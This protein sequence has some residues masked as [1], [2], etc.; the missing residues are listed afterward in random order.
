[1]L[2]TKQIEVFRHDPNN[3]GKP[4]TKKYLLNWINEHTGMT[5]SR[6][7]LINALNM[8]I[9]KNEIREGEH[10]LGFKEKEYKINFD[11]RMQ[12]KFKQPSKSDNKQARILINK[13]KT[14][15]FD[16]LGEKLYDINALI[17]LKEDFNFIKDEHYFKL[18]INT[19][20][21]KIFEIDNIIQKEMKEIFPN[22]TFMTVNEELRIIFPKLD[23]NNKFPNQKFINEKDVE[24]ERRMLNEGRLYWLEHKDELENDLKLYKKLCGK[25]FLI[26]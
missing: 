13:Y 18:V 20:R 21:K 2:L 11:P 1:M 9:E 19:K 24:S 25:P 7:S 5:W 23:D 8:F 22:H 12:G 4:F 10:R 6:P 14:K 3:W 26:P 16:E 17:K 15:D